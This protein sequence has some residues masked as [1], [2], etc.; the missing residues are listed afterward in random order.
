MNTDDT[1]GRALLGPLRDEPVPPSKVEVHQLVEAGRRRVRSRRWAGAGGAAVLTAAALGAAFLILPPKA[2]A[3]VAAGQ[4]SPT[5]PVR[6]AGGFPFPSS[7][8]AHLLPIPEGAD[9]SQILGGDPS[10]RYVVGTYSKTEGIEKVILWD[11][12]TAVTIPAPGDGLIAAVVNSHGVV[13]GTSD[14]LGNGEVK[15]FN[16]VYRN[17][18][19]SQLGEVLTQPGTFIAVEDINERGDILA[20]S[21]FDSGGAF[22]RRLPGI[23][24]NYGQ[25][26]FHE[27]ATTPDLQQVSALAI[28][29]DGT[30]VGRHLTAQGYSGERGLVW[31]PDGVLQQLLP[32]AGYG[33]G[34]AMQLLSNGW[35][36]GYYQQPGKQ[37]HEVA[38][39][40]RDLQTGQ[41]TPIT[42]LTVT[43][44]VNA[45][46]WVAG[47]VRESRFVQK[48]AIAG[49][50]GLLELPL[51]VGAVPASDGVGAYHLS[52]NGQT[53]AGNVA[54]PSDVRRAALWK[55]R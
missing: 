18:Q 20:N 33:P 4:S 29:D 15:M 10:G 13:A 36:V 16:W 17:G 26:G 25:D 27:L 52:D 5:P 32:P 19:I 8:E 31:T 2:P 47:L 46:G 48:P 30:V 14:R 42:A 39:L 21:R 12:G 49:D 3:E 55:C 53:V 34:G 43:G 35:A 45:S 9:Q 40:R 51:P 7:C 24:K 37:E 6:R 1:T 11:N 41:S 23:W 44:A 54:V 50:T 22:G 28:D 38:W